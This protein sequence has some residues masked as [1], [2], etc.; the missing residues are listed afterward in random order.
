MRRASTMACDRSLAWILANTFDTW[1]RTVFGLSTRRR[2]IDVVVE[3][4]GDQRQD[5]ELAVGQLGERPARRRAAGVGELADRLGQVVVEHDV[6]GRDR[7]A[8]RSR[9]AAARPP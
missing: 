6:A 1:L 9:R 4:L 3:A 8:A 2:A 7:R 5:V